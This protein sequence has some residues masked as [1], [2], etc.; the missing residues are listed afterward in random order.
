MNQRPTEF[1]LHI[2]TELAVR[3]MYQRMPVDR[4][5]SVLKRLLRSH[6]LRCVSV[7]PINHDM[8]GNRQDIQ[9]GKAT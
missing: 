9:T 4:L 3:D 6:G 7:Q 1:V 5:R 8:Q 2:K